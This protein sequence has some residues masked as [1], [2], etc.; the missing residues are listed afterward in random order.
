MVVARNIGRLGNN[1]FQIAAAIGYARKYGYEWAADS[2]NGLGEPYSSIHK[3][4]PN[5]P[6]ANFS[7]GIRHHEHPNAFCEQHKQHFNDCHFNYHDIPDL[8]ANVLL[9]GFF[10]SWKYF[11]HCKEEVK[12]VFKLPYKELGINQ[13]NGHI[14]IHVRRGDYVQHY[15]SFPPITVEYVKKAVKA[16]EERDALYQYFHVFSDDIN[17]CKDNLIQGVQNKASL[18]TWFFHE[19][20]EMEDLSIMA[21]CKHHIIANSSFSWWGAYLG[22]SPDKIVISPS[23]KRGNWFGMEAG[24]KQDVVDLLPPK[25]LQIDFR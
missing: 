23:C 20:T 21:S 12:E 6:K 22:H 8:G 1:M 17:W 15:G 19:G 25:W 16:L 10:Q 4:F 7:G 3:C 18:S 14:S 24:V 5:L 13:N 11:E 9:T 2:S